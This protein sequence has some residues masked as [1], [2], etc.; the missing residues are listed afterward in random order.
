MPMKE[1]SYGAQPPVDGYG[2][3]GFRISGEIYR[4]A[5][6]IGPAGAA[7]WDGD[8][9]ALETFAK[10]LDVVI[11]GAGDAMADPPEAL[12][13]ALDAADAPYESMATPAACRTYNVLLSEGRKVGAA[14]IP[15]DHAQ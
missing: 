7:L 1:V 8:P 3:G 9:A 13:A 6:L 12:A 11:F 4:G 5:V 14:L 10:G 2:I 15:V